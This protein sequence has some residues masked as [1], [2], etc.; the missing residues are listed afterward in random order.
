MSCF[1]ESPHSLPRG[2]KAS[3]NSIREP[4]RSFTTPTPE[5]FDGDTLVREIRCPILLLQAS[6]A[7][8]GILPDRDVERVLSIR[9]QCVVHRFAD[10]G[11]MM[12]LENPEPIVPVVQAFLD[13]L[14]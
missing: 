6:P 13:S 11:H 2:Q 10:L 4:S 12:H 9:P 7:L 14:T 5:E 1:P 3:P 8:G